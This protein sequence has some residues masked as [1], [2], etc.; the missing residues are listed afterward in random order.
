MEEGI[1][2]KWKLW[3]DDKGIDHR[4]ICKDGI[5]D[6]ERFQK[7][8]IKVLYILREVDGW[9]GGDLRE[10]L[11]DGP[12]YQMWHTIARWSAG[13]LSD[14]PEFDKIDNYQTMTEAIQK[15]SA[16]NIKKTSG[17]SI[18]DPT[19]LNAYCHMDQILLKEQ[20]DNIDPDYII[21][22]GTFDQIIWLLN[23]DLNVDSP[24]EHL[25]TYRE[26][27][28]VVI[29]W[30]HPNRANNRETYLSLKGIIR[31]HNKR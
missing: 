9:E 30:R 22:C 26:T 24:F 17:G 29:P 19:V 15:I 2:T 11:L 5:I 4:R 1:W 13:I 21:C 10:M 6:F 3:Y 16:I 31:K 23:L 28:S 25:P 7:C 14:F 18:H 20:I 12:K 8:K 27:G